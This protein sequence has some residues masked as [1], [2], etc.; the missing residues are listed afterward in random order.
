METR[1]ALFID[2]AWVNADSDKR[3]EVISPYTEEP[4]A[5]VPS[6]NTT[7]IDRAVTAARRAFDTTDWAHTDLKTRAALVTDLSAHLKNRVEEIAQT[8]TAEMGSPLQFSRMAQALGPIVMLDTF[9]DL[10]SELVL[11]D[12]REGLFGPTLIT[13]EPVGV[14]AAI[15]PWNV[16]LFV[17]FTKLAPALI[18]GCTVVLKP[19]AETPLSAYLLADALQQIGLPPG[20]VNVV[21]ADCEVS[22]Y[23]VTHPG[24]D[25]VAFTGSTAAGRRIAALCGERLRRVSLELGG[26]SACVVL[27]D[28]P[29]EAMAQNLMYASF[30]N[31]GQACI[32]QTRIL[33]P[34]SRYDEVVDAIVEQTRAL[35]VGD[36]ASDTT[37][38]GPLVS[39]RQRERVE[40]YL[41]I[42]TQ[43]GATVAIGGARPAEPEH[44]WFVAPTVFTNVDNH[45]RIA[46]EEIFGPVIGVIPY[47]NEDDALRIANDSDFGLSGSVWTQD[48]ARGVEIARGVRTGTYT[49]NG[50]TLEFRAPFG[51][52]KQS[53]LGR[54]LGVEGF[55]AYLEDKTISLPPGTPYPG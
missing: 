39:R 38:I 3:I 27:D 26:K 13:R 49:V 14:V 16:P 41:E 44:G 5:A 30:M 8:V 54:E 24:V 18:T 4:I 35:V 43:E 12:R 28:A 42:G 50:L 55:G 45:M 29:L 17:T 25:K 2:G 10:A 11:E 7:D 33:A 53:G 21:P 23:L 32:A 15:V 51:G 52:V 22:E 37:N 20:V 48:I 40:S 31:N 6:A 1:D 9:V 34:R 46:R 19:A 47:D 36:P